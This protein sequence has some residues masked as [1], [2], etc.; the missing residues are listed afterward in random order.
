M[1][2]PTLAAIL[3]AILALDARIARMEEAVSAG[4]VTNDYGVIQDPTDPRFFQLV[5]TKRH[6]PDCWYTC[7]LFWPYAANDEERQFIRLNV[8]TD[9]NGNLAEGVFGQL[10][11]QANTWND[12]GITIGTSPQVWGVVQDGAGVWHR[13]S[14]E[15]FPAPAGVNHPTHYAARF[16]TFDQLIEW[17]RRT[18]EE[19][20]S[21]KGGGR[22]SP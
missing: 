17:S 12:D 2:E 18:A 11:A 13:D 21:V 6:L 5:G 10:F 14:G 4:G 3:A 16:K 15:T 19:F 9:E 20:A 1:T 22:F 7:N 8:G